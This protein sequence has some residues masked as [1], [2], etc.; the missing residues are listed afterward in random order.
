MSSSN[1]NLVPF[2]VLNVDE[3][4]HDGQKNKTIKSKALFTVPSH[5]AKSLVQFPVLCRGASFDLTIDTDSLG[6]V[7]DTT[8]C[9]ISTTFLSPEPEEL[10]HCISERLAARVTDSCDNPLSELLG[11]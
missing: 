9:F 2:F 4:G 5:L 1:T 6:D 10:A 8:T 3:K 7:G 11:F